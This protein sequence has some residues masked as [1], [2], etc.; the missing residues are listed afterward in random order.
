MADEL[1]LHHVTKSFGGVK[2]VDAVTLTARKGEFLSILG[3]SG[4][5]K[6]TVQRLIGGFERPDSGTIRINDVMVEH[7]PPYKRDTATVFQSGALF[8]HK[9]VFDNVAYGLRVRGVSKGDIARKVKRAL[10]IVRL[11]GVEGR[12][13]S[14]ISGGQK[15]R[16]ALARGLVVEPALVLFDEPLSALDL[17]LRV[18][19]RTEI[20]AL[21]AELGF[22]AVYVTHDQSEAL[23]M[24]DRI[25]VM[26][27]G[28]CEQIDT[29]ER[30]FTAP[31][32]EFVFRFMGES[33]SLPVLVT[34]EGIS[35]SG[36]IVALPRSGTLTHGNARLFFR[37]AWL[38]LGEGAL[39]CDYRL[40]AK[41]KFTE[42]LG[43][44]HRYHLDVGGSVLVV[45]RRT[46]LAAG[47]GDLLDLGWNNHDM[48]VYQ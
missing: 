38:H 10:E 43:D 18:E 9:T 16:V 46:P 31:A 20:K 17:S 36:V 7:L 3:P 11:T 44:A 12:Y 6:T 13:P 15:Q 41:L 8:P 48:A 14:Q 42:F 5:G 27:N 33:S 37:P 24:S 21:H 23:A 22:T 34:P 30:V 29:P 26:R 25:A 40:L 19:L 32:N 39:A 35:V 47:A 2:A 28:R 45:D 1:A 4:S